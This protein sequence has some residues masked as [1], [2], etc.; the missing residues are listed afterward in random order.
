[1][2]DGA[3]QVHP[4]PAAL[5]TSPLGIPGQ[6]GFAWNNGAINYCPLIVGAVAIYAWLSW[7]L[8]AKNWFTGPV[9]TI[10]MP[11]GGA[12]APAAAGD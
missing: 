2:V 4:P 11:D 7:A 1:M 8:W 12:P 6:D 5:P 3:P 9:R 10:D